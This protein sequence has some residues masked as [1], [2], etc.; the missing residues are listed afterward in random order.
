MKTQAPKPQMA[1]TISLALHQQLCH[2]VCQSHFEMEDWEIADAAIRDWMVRHDPDAFPPPTARGVQWKQLF[3]PDG[4]LL[5]TTFNGQTHHCRVD[6]GLLLHEGRTSSP[7]HFANSLGGSRRNAWDCVWL[8]LPTCP[9]WQRAADL[10]PP[11]RAPIKRAMRPTVA[12]RER[13]APG[14]PAGN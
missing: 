9:S 14:R 11:R 8:L 1:L 5:R 4:T 3:L 2:A 10:R 7:N 13:R 6:G 12:E